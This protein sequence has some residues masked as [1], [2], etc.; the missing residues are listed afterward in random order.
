MMGLKTFVAS[1]EDDTAI[2]EGDAS[3][4]SKIAGTLASFQIGFEVLPGT[5]APVPEA[6]LNPYEIADDSVQIRGE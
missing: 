5:A 2:A 6:K 1:I 3:I 4:L